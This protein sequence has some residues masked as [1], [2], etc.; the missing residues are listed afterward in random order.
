MALKIDQQLLRTVQVELDS[1]GIQWYQAP[2]QADAQLAQLGAALGWWMLNCR[3]ETIQPS[4]QWWYLMEHTC[5]PGKSGT[6]L[7][8]AARRI[9]AQTELEDVELG[10][11]RESRRNMIRVL[12]SLI[13]Y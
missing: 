12:V 4:V 11:V 13:L 3:S 5:H 10:R 1:H 7:Q 8:H 9:A 2:F 6:D